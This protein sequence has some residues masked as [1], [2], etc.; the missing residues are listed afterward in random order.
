MLF[1]PYA[2][3]TNNILGA[4]STWCWN[5]DEANLPKNR[6][7]TRNKALRLHSLKFWGHLL[8]TTHLGLY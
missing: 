8:N 3:V 5:E 1:L 6:S 7:M 4:L 2:G